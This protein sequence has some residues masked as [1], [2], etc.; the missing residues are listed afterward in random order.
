MDAQI[1]IVVQGPLHKNGVWM[2]PVYR[3]YG[4]VIVSTWDDASEEMIVQCRE[5]GAQ[6]VTSPMVDVSEKMNFLNIHRQ[7]TSTLRGLELVKTEFVVKVRCDETYITL[8][9]IIAAVLA[10][11]HPYICLDI[12]VRP[13][14]L[15]PNHPS[16]HLI[17]G[18]T[19]LLR[20]AFTLLLDTLNFPQALLT[21]YHLGIPALALANIIP[22]EAMMLNT[23]GTRHGCP[24][25]WIG[26]ALF[27]TLG[28]EN[29]YD[30]FRRAYQVVSCDSVGFINK[31]GAPHRH[32]I[33]VEITSA[34]APEKPW[35]NK[36]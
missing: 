30:N 32:D 33:G 20:S 27:E 34:E 15:M 35:E 18:K 31:H 29:T 22:Y 5:Y 12:H 21:R 7:A 24:E 16:D 11:T 8:E 19:A 10:D 25:I 17:G 13:Y 23:C 6:V 14:G 28:W 36:S 26:E 1:T 2:I 3:Q 9:P 4:E